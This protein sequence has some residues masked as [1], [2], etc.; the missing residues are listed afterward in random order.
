MLVSVVK[1]FGS[2]FRGGYSSVRQGQRNVSRL[3]Y[4]CGCLVLRGSKCVLVR[5][6]GLKA[7][8]PLSEPRASETK[9]QAATR[10]VKEA[11]R[12]YSEEI[13][14]LRDVQ[15]AIA[16]DTS[17][18]SPVVLQVFVAVATN[19]TAAEGGCGCDPCLDTRGDDDDLYD[20]YDFEQAIAALSS[21][22]ERKCMMSV[23]ASLA[24]AVECGVVTLEAPGCFRP[25]V[26]AIDGH[27]TLNQVLALMPA[28]S[29]PKPLAIA[30]SAA[31]AGN[32][33]KTRAS[34]TAGGR[35]ERVPASAPSH[36]SGLICTPANK[37]VP[38]CTPA[39]KNVPICT[40]VSKGCPSKAHRP[41]SSPCGAGKCKKK[42]C[43]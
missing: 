23:T 43:C 15:P 10:A 16:Y 39:N 37:N 22:A 28:V 35:E 34:K 21:E 40:P 33:A 26:A 42:G 13:A 24:E 20:W 5:D 18:G 25:S 2:M 1:P 19:P 14:L 41:W 7:H 11:C 4:R 3:P 9:Q 17:G 6:Q 29:E 8:I 27:L 38:I 32:E 12:I 31:A 30:A 36:K